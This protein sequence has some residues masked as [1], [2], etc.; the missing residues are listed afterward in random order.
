VSTITFPTLTRVEPGELEFGLRSMTQVMESPL[1]G[2]IQT[3]EIA[4]S[5]RWVMSFGLDA[6]AESDDA[7]LVQAFLVKLRGR[8]N[9]AALWNFARPRP[10]GT[11]ATSGV[12]TSGTTAQGA[13][14]VSL[15]GCGAGATIL[16]GDLFA[17]A[18]ELKMAV[19][20]ATAN[21]SGVASV[22][23]EPPVRASGGW[24]SGATV[25]L[26]KPTALFVQASDDTRWSTRR[27]VRSDFRFEFVEVFA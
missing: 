12:T 5:A 4:F 3:A 21:G 25:T 24:S 8:A 26:D 23:F 2:G 10:Q 11:I 18:G 1:T 27:G 20:N 15:T 19:A 17:V 14:S 9:R 7:P 6:L 16:A 22:T 13:T